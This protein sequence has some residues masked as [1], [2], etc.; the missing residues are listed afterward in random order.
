LKSCCGLLSSR[1]QQIIVLGR[2]FGCAALFAKARTALTALRREVAATAFSGSEGIGRRR[3]CSTPT[4]ITSLDQ[5]V[6]PTSV[7]L[8][9]DKS[10]CS[11]PSVLNSSLNGAKNFHRVAWR[12]R[13]ALVKLPPPEDKQLGYL[14]LPGLSRRP[15]AAF[16]LTQ[17]CGQHC[18]L[19][20]ST[21][22]LWA[23]HYAHGSSGT[24]TRG[25]SAWR[26]W[27]VGA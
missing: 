22:T 18:H 16:P 15:G 1:C 19:T 23:G 14:F 9:A 25:A 26:G 6:L 12:R 5:S 4:S 21:R 3:G 11:Q 27:R 2:R 24:S 7:S 13:F 10:R 20:P 17:K 8:Q